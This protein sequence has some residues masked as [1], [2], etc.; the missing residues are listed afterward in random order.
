MSTLVR[1][2][3]C[4]MQLRLPAAPPGKQFRCPS[5]A[6]TF[7]PFPAEPDDAASDEEEFDRPRR[8]KRRRKNNTAKIVLSILGGCGVL[9][10]LVCGGL[11]GL[12]YWGLSPTS[13]PEQTEDYAEARARFKTKLVRKGPSP[14][15]SV[16]ETPPQ[17]ASEITYQ[18][19]GLPLKAWVSAKPAGPLA[20]RPAVLFLHGGFAF[21]EDDW[22]QAK[23]FRDA[24][25]VIMI[26]TLR[27]ENGLPGH[28]TLFYDE[29][30]D[31]LA[32]ADALA[33][34]PYVD[35]SRLYVSGHSAGG[36]LALLAAMASKRFRAAASLSGSPDQVAFVRDQPG[37]A[38]FN[39]VDQMELRMRSPLAFARSFQCPVRLY[40]GDEEFFFRG[41]NEKTAELA[42]NAG[43]DV[44]AVSVPGDHS[45]SV[46]EAMRQAIAFFRTK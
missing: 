24:G 32:A 26:P 45:T 43:L 20:K 19:G 12:V 16:R 42:R 22:D 40:Y 11:V 27:G 13:F 3:G 38:P 8:R 25:F 15:P 34:L 30:D 29:V 39:P 14:Q 23:P 36:T 18:S 35:G 6:T 17:G 28:F 2:P 37:L 9:V 21:G 46:P 31:V 1:C 4:D 41:S 7:V 5:C 33:R 10:L 44:Q